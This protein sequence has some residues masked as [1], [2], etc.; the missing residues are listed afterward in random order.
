M[1]NNRHVRRCAAR[2]PQAFVVSC[3]ISLSRIPVLALAVIA[4]AIQMMVV[5]VHIHAPQAAKF[6]APTS[7]SLST[8]QPSGVPL[9]K[10]PVKEDPANCPLC[11]V[12]SHSGAFVHSVAVLIALPF[13]VTVNFIV[14]TEAI[15]SQST[16]SHIWQGRA[17]PQA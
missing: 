15:V 16:V 6:L 7:I 2:K 11:Q 9:D 1:I 14:F 3:G 12:F 10:Y 8:D 5:Q 17:P 13:S 4:L